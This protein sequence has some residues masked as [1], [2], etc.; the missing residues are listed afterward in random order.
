MKQ[1]MATHRNPN[2]QRLR[3][4][5]SPTPSSEGSYNG[6]ASSVQ[7]AEKDDDKM[8]SGMKRER[9]GEISLPDAKRAL[10]ELEEII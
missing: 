9:E 7:T 10:G 1:H 2:D 5:S 8:D 6:E 4:S 3:N